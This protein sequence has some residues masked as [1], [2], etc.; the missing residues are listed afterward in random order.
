MVGRYPGSSGLA[1][2]F[3]EETIELGRGF[4]RKQCRHALE[5]RLLIA[6][7]FLRG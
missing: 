4:D 7:A 2:E 5:C 1:G 6:F 3:L